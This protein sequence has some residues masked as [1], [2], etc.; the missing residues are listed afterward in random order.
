MSPV[1]VSAP[2][3]EKRILLH[4]CCAPCSSA[5]IECLMESGIVP[6]IFYSNSN[7]FPREEYELRK[8]ECSRYAVAKG[9]TIVDDDY[10]HASWSCIAKG[11]E[12]CPERSARCLEC[13]RYRLLRA[14][15]YAHENGYKV[16]TTT[17]A[18]SR[19]KDLSQVNAAGEWA[20]SLFPDVSWWDR[21]WRKDGLQQRRSE[22][23]K[24]MNFYNQSWCGCEFSKQS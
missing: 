21:N 15:R 19:W 20:C 24:E 6:T 7:I 2:S 3:G 8:N 18:S 17:L 5:I 12:N 11:L 1:K 16:L 14:A 10:D 22:L 9:L 23:I 13:F 4:T